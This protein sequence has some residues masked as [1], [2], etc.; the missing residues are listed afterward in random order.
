MLRRPFYRTNLSRS[1]FANPWR[2]VERLQREMNRLFSDSFALTGGRT[3]PSFPAMNIWTDDDNAVI[4]AE[5]PGVSPDDI[6]VSVSGDT[7][8]LT[9]RRMPDDL[10]ETAKYHRRERAFGQFTRTFQLPF[11]V[12]FDKVEAVFKD[13][14]LHLSLPR[15]EE[16]KPKKIAVKA[17]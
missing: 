14:V 9:G 15:A 8:T 16:E 2:E 12:E 7:L 1:N 13:G 4:T 17:A 5:L 6:D 11:N 10:P 3:A